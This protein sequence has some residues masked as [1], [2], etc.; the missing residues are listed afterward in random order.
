VAQFI[1]P[2]PAQF[3]A[4]LKVVDCSAR[5]A[6][7]RVSLRVAA[8]ETGQLAKLGAPLYHQKH[9]LPVLLTLEQVHLLI[10]TSRH[11][12]LRKITALSSVQQ[13]LGAN[14]SPVNHES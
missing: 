10:G 8:Q 5:S 11:K 14:G 13:P 12:H 4:L 3:G 9:E 6:V 2:L 7:E 1:A